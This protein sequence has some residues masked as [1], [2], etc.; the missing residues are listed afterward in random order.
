M[1]QYHVQITAREFNDFCADSCIKI[2]YALVSHLQSNR[3]VECSNG[4]ILPGLKPRIFDKLKPYTGK[5]VKEFVIPSFYDKT[6][7]SLYVCPRINYSTHM[8][9]KCSQITKYHE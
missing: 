6:K 1:G 5:W 3:Q 9:Q 4:M 7:Y 8:D 2:N